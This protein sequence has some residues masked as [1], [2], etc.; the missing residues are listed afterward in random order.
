MRY[1]NAIS[2]VSMVNDC[3]PAGLVG[4]GWAWVMAAAAFAVEK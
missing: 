4:V 1:E 2:P 3:V